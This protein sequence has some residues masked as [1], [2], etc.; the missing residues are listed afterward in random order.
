MYL[1]S[2]FLVGLSLL[3]CLAACSK[4]QGQQLDDNAVASEEH[5]RQINAFLDSLND[6]ADKAEFIRY[7]SYFDSTSVFA[8]TDATERWDKPAFQ[9]WA[10]P[11]FDKGRAWSFTV[12]GKRNVELLPGAKAASFDELLSTQM[13]ICRGS[14]VVVRHGNT[15]KVRQYILSMTIPNDQVDK[16]IPLKSAQEDSLLQILNN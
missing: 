8:G 3:V 14:G 2:K 15:W 16:V 4:Q 10:K 1:C 7:F 6:A 11:I 12:L 9:A 13:K 5:I